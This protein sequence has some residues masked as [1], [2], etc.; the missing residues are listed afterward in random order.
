MTPGARVAAAIGLL[1]AIG[2][3]KAP[4]DDIV[5]RY[6]RGHRFAGVKDRGA[7]SGHVYAV[8]RHRAALDWWIA[9]AGDGVE[10]D[11]RTRL[12]AA[13]ILIEGWAPAEIAKAC[14]GDRFRPAPLDQRERRLIA[15]LSGRSLDHPD[16]PAPVCGNYPAWLE[17]HLYAALGRD[18]AREMAAQ[19]GEAQLDLRTNLLKSDREAARAAL[20]R[21][22]VQ[23]A[24]TPHSPLGLRVFERI[25]LGTLESFRR[26]LVEVQDEGSQLASL[27]VDARPGMR[28]VD[29]CAGVGGKTLALAAAM[30]NRG[31][32]VA[33]DIVA[34]RLERAGE[35]LRRAGASMVQR[36]PLASTRD[37]WVRRHGA[38][39]DRV[40]VDAPCTGTGTWRRNPDAKWRLTPDDLVELTALQAEI[41]DSAARLVRPGGRLIYVTCSLLGEENETQVER[42]LA[43]HADFALVPIAKVWRDAVGGDCPARGD[44]LRLTPARHGTDGFFVAVMARNAKAAA[45]PEPDG[46][47]LRDMPPDTMMPDTM[48]DEP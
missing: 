11:A 19:Q 6:F 9:R 20:G 18:L 1:A 46:E 36:M 16:M 30:G 13:L 2:E 39:F 34:R 33:C 5:G 31:H 38:S 48:T 29:F 22:G 12:F 14:D 35:R 8:L 32:L 40:L 3:G 7:I 23:A 44:M 45:V 42:F 15:T 25:P 27:L 41:L 28:V 17:P 43:G 26:G 10:V 24:R 21:E 4:A 37:K 47:D